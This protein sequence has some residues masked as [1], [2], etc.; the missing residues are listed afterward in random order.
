VRSV[1][2]EELERAVSAA[3][4]RGRVRGLYEAMVRGLTGRE[5]AVAEF[6]DYSSFRRRVREIKERSVEELEGLVR[7]FVRNAE[8]RG[9]RS[10]THRM[11]R[12]PVMSS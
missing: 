12:R 4:G 8:A 2:Y 1:D 5:R 3:I 10:T 9:P 7:E 11:R 6:D